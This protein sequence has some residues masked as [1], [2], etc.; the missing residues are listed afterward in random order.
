VAG[1]ALAEEQICHI[2]GGRLAWLANF[3]GLRRAAKIGA[4]PDEML[5]LE[6]RFFA[7]GDD[8]LPFFTAPR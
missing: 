6:L 1:V 4:K 5:R 7:N 3:D 2:V 8:K